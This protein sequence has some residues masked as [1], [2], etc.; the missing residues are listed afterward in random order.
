MDTCFPARIARPIAYL[1]DD[2]RRRV[3]PCG[4]CLVEAL[5]GHR[6]AIIWGISGQRCTDLPSTEVLNARADGCLVL[7]G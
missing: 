7:L 1:G 4:P 5:P 6:V 2:G 3:I